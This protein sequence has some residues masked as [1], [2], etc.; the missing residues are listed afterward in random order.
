MDNQKN[1][2]NQ[3]PDAYRRLIQG[4][5]KWADVLRT[6]LYCLLLCPYNNNLYTPSVHLA[7]HFVCT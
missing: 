2:E 7:F 3:M 6:R 4:V 5:I 1:M